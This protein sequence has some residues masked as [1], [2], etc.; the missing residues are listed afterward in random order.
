MS[1]N[2]D[3]AITFPVIRQSSARAKLQDY[4]KIQLRP[5]LETGRP[6]RSS[7][8]PGGALFA[9]RSL[10]TTQQVIEYVVPLAQMRVHVCF[11]ALPFGFI[12]IGGTADVGVWSEASRGLE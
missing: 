12:G 1:G 6:R 3:D 5:R 9:L 8:A 10:C 4:H 7:R 2:V 11:S